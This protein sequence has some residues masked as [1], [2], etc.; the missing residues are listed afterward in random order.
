MSIGELRA[1]LHHFIDHLDERFLR[2]MHSM[3]TRYQSGEAVGYELDG[4]PIDGR[5]LG[6][7]LDEEVAEGINGNTMSVQEL[8]EKYNKWLNRSK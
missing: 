3:I 1:E 2:A 4:T 6:E 5:I 8:E 7:L